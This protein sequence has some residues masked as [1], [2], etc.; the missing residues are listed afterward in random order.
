MKENFQKS[1][2]YSSYKEGVCDEKILMVTPRICRIKWVGVHKI[3]KWQVPSPRRHSSWL[4][5][6]NIVHSK[7]RCTFTPYNL[8]IHLILLKCI[9]GEQVVKSKQNINIPP[10]YIYRQYSLNWEEYNSLVSLRTFK[11]SNQTLKWVMLKHLEA[12]ISIMLAFYVPLARS[13]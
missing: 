3:E 11:N 5:V 2:N 6:E 4:D 8:N 9:R 12:L 1:K 10:T 7:K 13:T